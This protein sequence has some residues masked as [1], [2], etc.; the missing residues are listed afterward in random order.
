[1]ARL[2][3][4]GYA[5][6]ARASQIRD[7]LLALERAD[8]RE[9][10]EVQ[11]DDRALF[12]ERWRRVLLEALTPQAVAADARRAELRRVVAEGWSGRAAID[13]VGFRMVRA[14]RLF[15]IEQVYEALT[16]RCR[17]ADD[18]FS[19]WSLSQLEGPL[20]RLVEERPPWLLDARFDSW[21]SQLLSAA[22]TVIERLADERGSLAGRTWGERNTVVVR[23]PLS[24]AVPQLA[25]WLDVA[26][27]SLPG[28]GNMPRVQ[29]VRFGASMRMSVSPGREEQGLLHMPGGQSGHPRSPY[30]T[31]GH[32]AWSRGEPT[33]FLPGP[34][35]HRL[36]LRP[37]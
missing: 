14:F 3:D 7:D 13:S 33:P 23:H 31:A 11:L 30:Y 22:D 28:A 9:M 35:A 19:Y 24:L 5:L 37:D 10:L 15:L 26:P 21:Q 25:R 2:G 8:E 29:G 17:E 18:R 16:A 20:W 32:R 27:E 4:G 12:L 6:G 34:A 1:L 36:T